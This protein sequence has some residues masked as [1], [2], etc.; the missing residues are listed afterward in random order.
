[1]LFWNLIIMTP[2][3]HVFDHVFGVNSK[4]DNLIS[5]HPI[6][7]WFGIINNNISIKLKGTE[8]ME[9]WLIFLVYSKFE[10][11]GIFNVISHF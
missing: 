1:M 2:I 3:D 9:I 7:F 5:F 11:Q 6:F 4:V 10:L 8:Q